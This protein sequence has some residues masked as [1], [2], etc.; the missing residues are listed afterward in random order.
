LI[1][2]SAPGKGPPRLNFGRAAALI[3]LPVFTLSSAGLN[4]IRS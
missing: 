1:G 3:S 4:R 2:S